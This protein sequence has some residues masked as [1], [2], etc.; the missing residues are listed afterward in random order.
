MVCRT[1]TGPIVTPSVACVSAFRDAVI[2]AVRPFPDA[3]WI[4][5]VL[6]VTWLLPDWLAKWQYLLERRRV[7]LLDRRDT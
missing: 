5:V 7:G 6:R 3:L 4:M 1:W 2:S